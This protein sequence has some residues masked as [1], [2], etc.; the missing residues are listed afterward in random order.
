MRL[1]SNSYDPS[2]VFLKL[3]MRVCTKPWVGDDIA[4]TR[5]GRV[6]RKFL[7]IFLQVVLERAT[8]NLGALG[9]SIV[10]RISSGFG[11]GYLFVRRCFES[12][13]YFD[14]GGGHCVDGEGFSSWWATRF[15]KGRSFIRSPE[16]VY[17]HMN[18]HCVNEGRDPTST[19]EQVADVIP[20][21]ML[22][23]S[24]DLMLSV[25]LVGSSCSG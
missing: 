18:I 7:C 20:G 3:K 25:A 14:L 4:V 17:G 22:Q 2:C 13:F 16:W 8:P 6:W 5:Q 19:F 1:W 15:D 21:Q 11:C 23:D 12:R 9:C 10:L 24:P